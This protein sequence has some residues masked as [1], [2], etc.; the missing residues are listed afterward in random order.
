M[1]YR[2]NFVCAPYEFEPEIFEDR[3]IARESARD[4]VRS[5]MTQG[6]DVGERF[7]QVN[8]DKWAIEFKPT[9]TFLCVAWIEN[10]T[11]HHGPAIKFG[12]PIDQQGRA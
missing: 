11:L 1:R 7:V 4:F 9:G 3:E 8:R 12:V 10:E 2:V 5:H 6:R